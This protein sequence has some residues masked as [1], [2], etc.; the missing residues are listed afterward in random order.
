MCTMQTDDTIQ[1]YLVAVLAQL[2]AEIKAAGYSE[3]SLAAVIGIS[4]GVFRR[5]LRGERP[6]PMSVYWT[7]LDALALDETVF[8]G[9]ARARFEGR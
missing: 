3:K 7:I 1:R 8:V 2:N 9:R 6:L 5:Y 4:Y